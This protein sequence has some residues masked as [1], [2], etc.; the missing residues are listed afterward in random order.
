MQGAVET[1]EDCAC[2]HIKP[3]DVAK[4]MKK[5]FTEVVWAA[6]GGPSDE[7]LDKSIN[8]SPFGKNIR[9]RLA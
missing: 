7:I 9:E 4:Q 5:L 8:G 6:L 1:I 2:A 3:R